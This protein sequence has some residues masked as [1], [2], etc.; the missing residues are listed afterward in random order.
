MAVPWLGLVRPLALESLTQLDPGAPPPIGSGLYRAELA[1]VRS[2]GDVNAP[3]AIRS[4]AETLTARYFAAIPFG[5]ME[6]GLRSV[7]AGMDISDSARLFAATNTSIADAIG[8]AWNAKLRYMWWRPIT[9]IHEGEGDD[10][11]DILT[12]PDRNWNSLLPAPPYPEWPSGLCSVIGAMTTSL[13]HLT[14][15]LNLTMG[16]AAVGYRTWTSKTALDD[17]AIEARILS[18][19]HFRTSDVKAIEIGTA[20]AAYILDRYFASND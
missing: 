4:S 16:T 15:G 20:S 19:I 12:V 13:Q 18:G 17:T 8:T 14:G 6:E 1:E 9:A 10:D 5:P 7:A 2:R 11:G 3:E